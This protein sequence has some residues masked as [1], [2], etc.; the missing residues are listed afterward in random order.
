ME[1][2]VEKEYLQLKVKLRAA[3]GWSGIQKYDTCA[4]RLAPALDQHG[5]PV[6]GLEQADEERLE[7]AMSLTPGTLAKT[8]VYWK[9]FSVAIGKEGMLINTRDPQ[10]ELYYLFLKRDKRV[11]KS[12]KELNARALAVMYS[13]EEEAKTSNKS[14][15][16]K[17]KAFQKFGAMTHADM[18]KVLTM[19]GKMGVEQLSNDRVESILGDEVELNP[20]R[21]MDIVGDPLFAKKIFIYE[22]IEKGIL[23]KSGSR[24]TYDGETIGMDLNSAIAYLSDA[25]NQTLLAGLK[26]Q[27][28]K[29]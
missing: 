15:E 5:R 28:G 11:S 14:R 20:A 18:K 2:Q 27:V 21:F 6:T 4:L 7:K 13:D 16:V 24:I 10:D 23:K 25:K 29:E 1:N 9:N 12:L 3:D 8:S 22:L 17:V 19:Y 26:K